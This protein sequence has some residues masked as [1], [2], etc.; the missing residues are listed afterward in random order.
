MSK[1]S[2]PRHARNKQFAA[3]PSSLL[4]RV[5]FR[6]ELLIQRYIVEDVSAERS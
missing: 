3:A 2:V 4:E 5:V 1:P 6:L